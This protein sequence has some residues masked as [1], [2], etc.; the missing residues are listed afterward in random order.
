MPPKSPSNDS[1]YILLD[2]VLTDNKKPK[3]SIIYKNCKT[4]KVFVTKPSKETQ[5][6][7]L[8]NRPKSWLI[9]TLQ[10]NSQ[11]NDKTIDIIEIKFEDKRQTSRILNPQVNILSSHLTPK[12]LPI[13]NNFTDHQ[14]S[15]KLDN[16]DRNLAIKEVI[17][18][19]LNYDLH[20]PWN[21]L[22]IIANEETQ[23]FELKEKEIPAPLPNTLAPTDLNP[24]NNTQ[25]NS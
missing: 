13:L 7:L 22:S 25:S 8:S 15:F 21:M 2:V 18:N 5:V 9:P 6:P 11:N 4:S 23:T 16:D 1:E 14:M 17:K 24:D 12:S 19:S 10:N 3:V 20:F